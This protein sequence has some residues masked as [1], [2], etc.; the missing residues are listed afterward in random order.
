[1][2]SRASSSSGCRPARMTSD[3]GPA[4]H[5]LTFWSMEPPY[6]EGRLRYHLGQVFMLA[7]MHRLLTEGNKV[8]AVVCDPPVVV[9]ARSR[10]ESDSQRATIERF[11]RAVQADDI[12]LFRLSDLCRDTR[13]SDATSFG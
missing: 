9:K 3:A 12:G 7:E 5:Y 13:R 8:S 4:K 11:L 1:M 2:K 6:K 10:P